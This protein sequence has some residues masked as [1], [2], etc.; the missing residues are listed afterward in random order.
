LRLTRLAAARQAQRPALFELINDSRPV[1]WR[2]VAGRYIDP[3]RP[4]RAR[5]SLP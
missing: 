4:C 3:E 1:L 2:N 5:Y